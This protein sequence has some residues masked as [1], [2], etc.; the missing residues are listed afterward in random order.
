MVSRPVS[1]E[2]LIRRMTPADNPDRQDREV[3]WAEWQA[4]TGEMILHRFVR[5]RNNT[6]EA[7]ED[8]VQDTL[9]TAYLGLESGRY[10]PQEGIPFVAYVIGIARNK[11]REARRRTIRQVDLDEDR[12]EFA[13]HTTSLHRQPEYDIERR[14]QKRLLKKGISRLPGPRRSVLEQYLSGAST[15]EIA[16]MLEIS[17]ALVRQHKC[18]ALRALQRDLRVIGW[19]A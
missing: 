8:I 10:Q 3:A 12:E 11:I 1:D 5:A 6:R 9:I 17:E 13:S 15:D 2:A 4:G 16:G 14:E 19:A 18:R 7:D